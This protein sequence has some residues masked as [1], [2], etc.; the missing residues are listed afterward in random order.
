VLRAARFYTHQ[1][2]NGGSVFLLTP[3]ETGKLN[4]LLEIHETARFKNVCT[5]KTAQEKFKHY[6]KFKGDFMRIEK[7]RGNC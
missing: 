7:L 3:E 5:L 1:Q 6:Y 2:K 4:L